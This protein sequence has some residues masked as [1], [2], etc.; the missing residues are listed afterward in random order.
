MESWLSPDLK[1]TVLMKNSDPRMGESTM[2]LRN[3]DRSEPD[4]A[5]F[6]MPSDY[7]I[8]NENGEFEMKIARP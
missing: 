2:R 4:P 7:K 6:R 5:L 8:V 1:I 3:I